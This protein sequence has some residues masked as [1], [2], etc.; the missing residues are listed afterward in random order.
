[1]KQRDRPAQLDIA[2]PSEI[3][4][5]WVAF[6]EYKS[7]ELSTLR[8]KKIVTFVIVDAYRVTNIAIN[9]SRVCILGARPRNL[10]VIRMMNNLS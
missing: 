4:R 10:I 7:T 6:T 5:S 1:M 2:S 9:S 8:N 3:E